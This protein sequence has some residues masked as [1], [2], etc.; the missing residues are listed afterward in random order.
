[1]CSESGANVVQYDDE[2]VQSEVIR[3]VTSHRQCSPGQSTAI[4]GPRDE[5]WR[6]GVAEMRSA[7][8]AWRTPKRG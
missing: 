2:G 1:M 3:L 4:G 8:D 5:E 6:V 7:K